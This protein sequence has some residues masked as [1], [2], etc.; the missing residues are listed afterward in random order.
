MGWVE[1]R[2]WEE[3]LIDRCPYAK[4]AMQNNTGKEKRNSCYPERPF[5]QIAEDKGGNNRH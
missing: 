1:L 2:I 3:N 5:E 4:Q